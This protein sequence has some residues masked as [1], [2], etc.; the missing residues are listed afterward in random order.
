MDFFSFIASAIGNAISGPILISF[1]YVAV[2]AVSMLFTAMAFVY[3]LFV[4][5]SKVIRREKILHHYGSQE[6]RDAAMSAENDLGKTAEEE[7]A[8]KWEMFKA[9]FSFQNAKKGI[10]TVVKKRPWGMRHIVVILITIYAG[11]ALAGNG[12]DNQ[13]SRKKF[14]WEST[15]EFNLFWSS[16]G[17]SKS[18]FSLFSVGLLLP[19]ATEVLHVSDMMLV[20]FSNSA[21]LVSYITLQVRQTYSEYYLLMI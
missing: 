21:S 20:V 19:L 4:K 12:L 7:T 18:I 9:M 14:E 1:G 17:S 10:G 16:Y 2:F 5:E 3:G 13:Y 11:H 15:D 6:A 8:S